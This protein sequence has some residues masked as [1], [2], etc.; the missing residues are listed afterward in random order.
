ML[1]AIELADWLEYGHVDSDDSRYL[2]CAT[3][4]R[5]LAAKVIELSAMMNYCPHCSSAP[6]EACT[7]DKHERG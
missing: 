7:G 6:G 1:K 4:L 2:D 3:E 5:K